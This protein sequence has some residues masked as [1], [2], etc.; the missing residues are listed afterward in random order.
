[1]S[2]IST[3][4]AQALDERLRLVRAADA[5]GR[6]LEREDYLALAGV[7][8]LLPVVMMIVGWYL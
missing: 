5:E 8:A 1:M 6:G 2:D 4:E 3:Q 7:C